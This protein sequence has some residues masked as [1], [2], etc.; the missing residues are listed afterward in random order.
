MSKSVCIVGGSIAGCS[1]A[2]PI[3]SNPRYSVKILERMPQR[4]SGHGAGLF[5]PIPLFETLKHRQYLD[6]DFKGFLINNR[7]FVVRDPE[8]VNSGR[9]LWEQPLSAIS[10]HWNELFKN[11]RKRI[12]DEI[13]FPDHEVSRIES[14]PTGQGIV[15]LA[16]S[17]TLTA[18]L[19]ICADGYSSIGRKLICP[20]AKLCY[21]G[22]HAWRGV[23]PFA[24]IENPQPFQRSVPYFMNEKGHLL[25]YPIWENDQLLLNWVF[26]EKCADE[27]A[28]PFFIDKLDRTHQNSLLPGLLSDKSKRHLYDYAQQ[29]LPQ[30]MA[31]IV[32]MTEKPFI[33]RILDCFMEQCRKGPVINLGDAAIVLRPHVGAGA[34]KAIEDA[35]C[36]GG[37]LNN[38]DYSL[39]Q[40][41]NLWNE[42]Q[43]ARSKDLYALS[44]RMGDGLVLNPPNWDKMNGPKMIDWWQCIVGEKGWYPVKQN[45]RSQ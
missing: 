16:N 30:I 19:I 25:C 28:K 15:T 24:K 17:K 23:I 7:H 5:L 35:L 36:L 8:N 40:A 32:M 21:P 4:L 18:D 34:A 10:V 42:Q 38:P 33:Q 1:A 22:Y 39:D 12:P 20:D 3:L 43:I 13:Y 6:D 2:L 31:D 45:L 29:A 14:S 9:T 37:Y 26:F 41:L 11:L 27:I 44:H